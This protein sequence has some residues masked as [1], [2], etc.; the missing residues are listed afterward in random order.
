MEKCIR[1]KTASAEEHS[2]YCK[3]CWDKLYAPKVS[4]DDILDFAGPVLFVIGICAVYYYL[5]F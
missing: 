2:N 5:I 3:E 4:F 1:C